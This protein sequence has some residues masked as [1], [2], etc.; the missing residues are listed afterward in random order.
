MLRPALAVAATGVAGYLLWQLFLKLVAPLLG[1]L[2]GFLLVAGKVVF[3]AVL[4][5]VAVW[6]YKRL[7]RRVEVH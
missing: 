7:S 5:L 4:V 6:L 1:V 3:L 2:A